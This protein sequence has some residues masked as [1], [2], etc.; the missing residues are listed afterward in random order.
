MMKPFFVVNVAQWCVIGFVDSVFCYLL[1][2]VIPY[3]AEYVF[4]VALIF[5]SYW[6]A[7]GWRLLQGKM[8]AA[9]CARQN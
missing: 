3:W 2:F 7:K 1:G 4:G 9:K 5:A 6:L 8:R